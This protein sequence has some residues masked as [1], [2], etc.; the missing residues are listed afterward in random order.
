[1]YTIKFQK[2]GLLHAYIL[3][4]LSRDNTPRIVPYIDEIS[5]TEIPNPTIDLLLYLVVVSNI[6]YRKCSNNNPSTVCIQNAN[7]V[8]RVRFP[9]EYSA[10]TIIIVDSYL[11]YRRR[12]NGRRIKISPYIYTNADVVPYSLYLSLYF[13]TYINIEIARSIKVVKYIYKYV[14]KGGDR[15]VAILYS[16]EDGV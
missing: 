2:R 3:I 14:Y 6:I 12:D 4:I 11:R 10:K 8:Y 5:Y 13:N 1:M 16:R 9:K 15:T 7:K